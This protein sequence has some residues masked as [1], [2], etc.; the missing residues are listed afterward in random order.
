MAQLLPPRSYYRL[1][2][3]EI[4]EKTSLSTFRRR[5]GKRSCRCATGEPHES[6]A[7]RYTEGGRT[8]LVTLTET[9]VAEVTAALARYREAKTALDRSAASGVAAL[10]ARLASR[11]AGGQ[12]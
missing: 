11:R 4:T 10:R 7:L 1:S 6:P 2:N 3:A 8:K 12:A 9:D 5:C